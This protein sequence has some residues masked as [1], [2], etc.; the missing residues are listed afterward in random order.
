MVFV[1]VD[2][3]VLLLVFKSAEVEKEVRTERVLSLV[4]K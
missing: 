1:V 4:G 2:D 3:M